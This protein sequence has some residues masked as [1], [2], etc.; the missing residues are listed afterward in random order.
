MMIV[1]G[2][3]ETGMEGTPFKRSW[4][5]LAELAIHSPKL[6]FP[7]PPAPTDAPFQ[8]PIERGGSENR[9]GVAEEAKDERRVSVHLTARVFHQRMLKETSG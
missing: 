4:G 8:P 1:V 2:D 5:S 3:D 9:G 6:L 7:P